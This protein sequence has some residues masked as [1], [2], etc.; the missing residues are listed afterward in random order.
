MARGY[1]APGARGSVTENPRSSDGKVEG[2][3][4]GSGKGAKPSRA[5]YAGPGSVTENPIGNAGRGGKGES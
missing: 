5:Q 2:K 1:R 3:G 4:R